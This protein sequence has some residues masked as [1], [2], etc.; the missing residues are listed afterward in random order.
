MTFFFCL[1]HPM[2][3]ILKC[4]NLKKTTT[5]SYTDMT[6]LFRSAYDLN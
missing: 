1:K 3:Q 2:E 5:I 4:P 6:A